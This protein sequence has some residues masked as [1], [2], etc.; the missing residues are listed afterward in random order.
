MHV[1]FHEIDPYYSR[2]DVKVASDVDKE[3]QELTL[4]REGTLSDPPYTRS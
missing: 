1:I 4:K 3:F 2:K